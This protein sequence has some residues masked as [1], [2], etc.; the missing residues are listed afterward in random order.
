MKPPSAKQRRLLK[1]RASKHRRRPKPPA[2]KQRRRHELK[3]FAPKLRPK[4]AE[5]EI[6][7]APV[8]NRFASP[9]SQGVS[10]KAHAAKRQRRLH[11]QEPPAS[12]LDRKRLDEK[13]LPAS[14]QNAGRKRQPQKK[15]IRTNKN[16]ASKKGLWSS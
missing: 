11:E 2:S 14:M 8:S 16:L 7:R 9:A 1:Q 10:R 5:I 12:K 15:R 3:P 4:T 13:K 6:E